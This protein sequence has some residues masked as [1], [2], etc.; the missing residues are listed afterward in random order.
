MAWRLLL[1]KEMTLAYRKS[2]LQIFELV[3]VLT[4]KHGSCGSSGQGVASGWTAALVPAP[5][6]PCGM[7]K[8]QPGRVALAPPVLRIT[9]TN[10][11]GFAESDSAPRRLLGRM[12]SRRCFGTR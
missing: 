9:C 2:M 11:P 3:T 8:S 12:F 10:Q 1:C 6:K 5:H 7:C 4:P